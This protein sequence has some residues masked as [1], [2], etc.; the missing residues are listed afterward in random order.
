MLL[1]MRDRSMKPTRQCHVVLYK[2]RGETQ[3]TIRHG[4]I[5][6]DDAESLRQ[7]FATLLDCGEFYVVPSEPLNNTLQMFGEIRSDFE[8]NTGALTASDQFAA[9]KAVIERLLRRNKMRIKAEDLAEAEVR[10]Q[11]EHSIRVR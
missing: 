7:Y 4:W 6:T 10:E 11:F 2:R 1:A 3:W 9:R 5:P 8:N